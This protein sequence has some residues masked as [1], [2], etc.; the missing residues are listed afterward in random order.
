LAT[1]GSTTIPSISY[2]AGNGLGVWAYTA[3]ADSQSVTIPSGYTQQSSSTDGSLRLATRND[4]SGATSTGTGTSTTS[5]TQWAFAGT[6]LEPSGST[7][8]P[9]AWTKTF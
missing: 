8:I 2:T 9:I 5:D 7:V 6:L 4:T 3:F 1:A